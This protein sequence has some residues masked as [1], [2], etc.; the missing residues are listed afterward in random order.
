MNKPFFLGL[1]AIAAVSLSC[2][3]SDDNID[4][5][6]FVVEPH[7]LITNQGPFGS[8]NGTIT[9][10][11]TDLE[12]VGQNYYQTANAGQ[13]LGNIVQSVGFYKDKAYVVSNNSDR[14]DVVDRNTFENIETLTSGLIQPRY[15]A[16]ANGKGYVSCWGDP[17]DTTDDYIAVL[18]LEDNTI[19]KTITV[20]EGP[21]RLLVVGDKLYVAEQGGFGYSNTV[22][23]IDTN[24]DTVL[25]SVVVGDVPNSL[26]VSDTGFVYVL[27]AGKPAFTMDE[28]N[29]TLTVIAPD[30]TVVSTA[31]FSD[32]TE[33]PSGLQIDGDMYYYYLNGALYSGSL[34]TFEEQTLP[35]AAVGFYF[36]IAVRD[37]IFYGSDAKDFASDGTLDIKNLEQPDVTLATI[38]VGI[39]PGG[40]FFNE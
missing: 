24:A 34:D 18:N 14:V 16:A 28:T 33:H 38:P 30:N 9:R 40:I 13:T 23:I 21:E 17:F 12:T 4:R 2:E 25:T 37:G 3:D 27:A 39:I 15:F 19:I 20:A 32:V 1:I 22:K 31:T 5:Q 8:G 35:F 10:I 7:I 29:A 6:D 36:T 26:E 11:S